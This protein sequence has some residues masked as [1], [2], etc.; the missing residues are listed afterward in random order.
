MD[1]SVITG[2]LKQYPVAVICGGLFMLFALV[3]LARG[4][5]VPELTLQETEL[6]ARMNT[7]SENIKN[8][9]N[10]N[11]DTETLD[12][13]VEQID[14]RLFSRYERAVNINFF[15]GLEDEAGVV[16][17]SITQLPQ[18]DAIYDAKGVRKLNLYSTLVYNINVSGSF[19][20]V[21]KFLH[22]LHR[23]DRIIRVADFYVAPENELLGSAS[24]DARLRVLVLARKD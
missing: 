23:V 6:N 4:G 24:V 14:A 12:L 9:K 3:L 11:E 10:L 21:L 16:I 2:K 17:T 7:I 15:Y 18:P 5:V 8:S 20:E 13:M 22:E 19:S 1:F